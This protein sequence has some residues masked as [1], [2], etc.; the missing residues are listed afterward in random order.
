MCIFAIGQ[1]NWEVGLKG[2]IEVS[3]YSG[4]VVLSALT[5]RQGNCEYPG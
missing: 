1:A 4:G 3:S 5:C 2:G